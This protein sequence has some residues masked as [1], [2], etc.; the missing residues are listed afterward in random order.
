V[1]LD[2]PKVRRRSAFDLNTLILRPLLLAT[3]CG[4]LSGPGADDSAVAILPAV[5]GVE[6]PSLVEGS[7]RIDRGEEESL[8][9]P[10]GEYLEFEVNVDLG[11]L[12]EAAVGKVTMSSGVEPFMADLPRPGESLE[13]GGVFAGWVRITARGGHLGY[14]LDHTITTRYLPQEWPSLI[15]SE[16]QTGSENRKREVKVGH[17]AE[18]W[19]SAYR[20]NS[21]CR[22]CSRREHYVEASLPW[23]NDYHCKKCKRGEHRLWN[24]AV[25]REVPAQSVDIL[26]AV[27]L[28]RSIVRGEEPEL[29]MS[30]LQKDHLWTVKLVRGK[31]RELKVPAGT[32]SCREVRLSV[33]LPEGESGGSQDFSGLFGIKGALKIWLHEGS[34]IP[35]QIEGDVPVGE[36]IDLHANIRLAK[37]RGT[38]PAFQ[39]VR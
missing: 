38:P 3:L 20:G 32:F 33:S 4:L 19:K 34:G 1:G 13:G 15:H 39:S 37:F 6:D 16:V 36:I 17:T 31:V 7:F 29:E 25:E 22:G 30:M 9:V 18:G 8:W 12:G 5:A 27:Y 10:P 35:V 23:N 26:S 2:R 14:E 21:H 24:K 11:V 28:A